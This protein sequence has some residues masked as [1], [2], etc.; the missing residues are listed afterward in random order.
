[1]LRKSCRERAWLEQYE[2]L[3]HGEF[4]STAWAGRWSF[5]LDLSGSVVKASG[6]KGTASDTDFEVVQILQDAEGNMYT[7]LRIRIVQG[8]THQIRVHVS[9]FCKEHLHFNYYGVVGDKKYG[10]APEHELCPRQF[11]H[12]A[13][14]D[15]PLSGARKAFTC[16]LPPD[17]L[18]VVGKL[19]SSC[20]ANAALQDFRGFRRMPAS[21]FVNSERSPSR[22]RVEESEDQASTS[23]SSRK[24]RSRRRGGEK[25][26][27]RC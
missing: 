4:P 26:S 21:S 1:M 2:A 14:L 19:S 3:V 13:A 12:H 27:R 8:R 7:R 25:R 5:P 16:S 10:N 20:G 15:L 24:R 6:R 18:G 23:S 17:L 22:F 9:H 11:L